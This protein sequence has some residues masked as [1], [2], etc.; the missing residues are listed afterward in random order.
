M[1]ELR[2]DPLKKSWTII[3]NH[4][5]R[6]PRDFPR[7]RE[8]S[9]LAVCPFC[10][11][12]EEKSPP[13]VFAIRPRDS[14]PNTPG[15]KVRVVP[16]KYPVLRIEGDLDHRGVGLYDVMNGVGAHEVIIES[17]DHDR[18]MA[19]F[20]PGEIADVFRAYRVRLLDLRRD[21]RFRYIQ[22]F[23]NHG[24]EAGAAIPH[25]HSQLI[26]LP[27]TPTM[28]STEL[29]SCRAYY[30]DKERCLICDLLAQELATQDRIVLDDGRFVVYAPYASSFPFELHI[31]G[32]RHGHDFALLTD[33]EFLALAETFKEALQ[34][35]RSVL[36]DP[37]YNF[38]LH[39]APPAH[40][41][42][43][44]PDHW[45]TLPLDFHWHLELVPRLTKIAG[46]EWGSG[47]HINPTPPEEAA[48]FLRQADLVAGP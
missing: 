36:R 3:I 22:I 9:T 37:P 35:L 26:A 8:T 6:R 15:W 30:R 29:S 19:D 34:R 24:L 32:R 18:S 28:V 2:W 44:K 40:P 14:L 27:L 43:G 5:W 33:E 13:E 46:F 12:R 11:G 23:G 7:E 38:I 48:R 39:T 42:P 16:N 41:R 31:A 1:S 4:L 21:A 20:S 17:P 45:R 10:Y 47:F 25:P